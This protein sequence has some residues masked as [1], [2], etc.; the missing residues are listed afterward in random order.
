MPAVQSVGVGVVVVFASVLSCGALCVSAASWSLYGAH[1]VLQAVAWTLCMPI[2]TVIM[3]MRGVSGRKSLH[4]YI[5]LV[6][7]VCAW[8]GTGLMMYSKQ[9]RGSAHFATWHAQLALALQVFNLIEL[10]TGLQLY[11]RACGGGVKPSRSYFHALHKVLAFAVLFLSPVV[12]AVAL[13]PREASRAKALVIVLAH[14][15]AVLTIVGRMVAK[16]VCK[17]K[18]AKKKKDKKN[19]GAGKAGS[20]AAA[21]AAAAA[22]AASAVV[23]DASGGT[24]RRVDSP[25]AS[26][27]E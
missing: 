27:S 4:Y 24:R 21:P 17:N 6:G 20:A 26:P 14:A 2:G 19:E 12:V 7:T 5:N 1:V 15:A 25:T 16:K 8:L 23:D 10:V 13:V 18:L 9:T 11:Y 22:A 3:F